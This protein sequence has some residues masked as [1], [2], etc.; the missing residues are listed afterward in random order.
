MCFLVLHHGLMCR[1]DHI[2]QNTQ[3][4]WGWIYS[5]VTVAGKSAWVM[6]HTMVIVQQEM[7]DWQIHDSGS[8]SCSGLSCP[9]ISSYTFSF[10]EGDSYLQRVWF[11]HLLVIIIW[12]V[13]LDIVRIVSWS[14]CA[15][16]CSQVVECPHG[17]TWLCQNTFRTIVV[18]FLGPVA[19]WRS[20]R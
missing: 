15:F 1:H 8:P 19:R 2:Q 9:L 7:F 11:R 6:L 3:R 5:N 12:I 13:W 18:L 16:W 4:G 20:V 14:T 17:R 10:L